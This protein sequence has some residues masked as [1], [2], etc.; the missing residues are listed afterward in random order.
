MA[1]VTVEPLAVVLYRPSSMSPRLGLHAVER[2]VA[3]RIF[4]SEQAASEPQFNLPIGDDDRRLGMWPRSTRFQ[5]PRIVLNVGGDGPRNAGP[6]GKPSAKIE[7]CAV[8]S[9]G[10]GLIAVGSSG[11]RSLET[12]DRSGSDADPRSVRPETGL[13]QLAALCVQ[14]RLDDFQRYGP[15]PPGCCRR[16][17][18]VLGIYTCTNPKLYGPIRPW[19][20]ARHRPSVWCAKLACSRK[21]HRMECMAES[22][23][24]RVW[25]AVKAQIVEAIGRSP[26]EQESPSP[27][28]PCSRRGLDSPANEWH[29][30]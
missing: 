15:A 21:C 23:P 7:R 24:D 4:G 13:L 3:S 25:P 19:P 22:T 11:D 8:N 18:Q 12:G 5:R 9:L 1:D 26:G 10:A 29:S 14:S 16:G 30:C 17:A 28:T 6:L 27:P 2:V 20:R